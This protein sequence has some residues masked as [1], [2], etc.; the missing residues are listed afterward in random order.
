MVMCMPITEDV[1]KRE[2][3]YNETRVVNAY[4]RYYIDIDDEVI[5]ENRKKE[6]RRPL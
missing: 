2:C 3:K 6:V 5:E 1:Y 4:E